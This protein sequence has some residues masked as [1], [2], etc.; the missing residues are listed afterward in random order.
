MIY[1]QLLSGKPVLI[2]D[3]GTTTA[4]LKSLIEKTGVKVV[5]TDQ[6]VPGVSADVRVLTPGSTVKKTGSLLSKFIKTTAPDSV[7]EPSLVS[8]LSSGDGL[9]PAPVTVPSETLAYVLFTSGTTS[10]PK[11]VMITYGALTAHLETFRNV[12]GY[13]PGDRMLN[14]LPGHHADG[15]IQGLFLNAWCGS[16]WVRP[17]GFSIQTIPDLFQSFKRYRITHFVTVP[18]MLMFMQKMSEGFTDALNSPDFRFSLS[19]ASKLEVSLWESFV[20]T[21]GKPLYNMYGLT[22]SVT[23]GIFCGPSADTMKIGT[24]GKPV[25][26]EIRIDR[27]PGQDS[28][29][30]E[31]LLKG[32]NLLTGYYRNP[33]ATSDVMADGWFKTGDLAMVDEDGFVHITGRKKNLIIRGG[34]NVYAEEVTAA[35]NRNQAVLE[36]LAVGFPD[37]TWGERVLVAVHLKEGQH[38]TE[39]DILQASREFLAPEH[40]PDQIVFLGDLPKGPAGKVKINEVRD[41]IQKKISESASQNSTASDTHDR[42]FRIAA[43]A[44]SSPVQSLTEQ[45]NAASTRGW[46]SLGHMNLV[47]GLEKEFGIRFSTREVISIDSLGTAIRM[48][49]ERRKN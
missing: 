9:D 41:L 44:F 48:V 1:T 22:E 36:C 20:S 11:G 37:D 2:T 14:I 7:A 3:P 35:I 45:T 16:A 42:V 26:C 28:G 10:E 33:A 21:F 15:L 49:N 25:D 39:Q 6:T 17:F 24:I 30:G 19:S 12:Y 34:V 27:E 47:T 32:P 13:K 43:K 18:T 29:P 46:D 31:L 38:P 5:V 40:V 23:G 8:I 4:G